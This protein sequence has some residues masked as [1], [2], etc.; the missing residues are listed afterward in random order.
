MRRRTFI[1][2][3]GGVAA[4]PVAA[5][6]QQADRVRRLGIIWPIDDSDSARKMWAAAFMQGLAELGWV[7]GGNLRIDVRWNPRT[8]EQTRMLIEE[9]VGLQ[10]DALVTGTQG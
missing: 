5:R 4:W 1:S 2:L 3:L 9:V 8:P 6:A 7:E 10:P